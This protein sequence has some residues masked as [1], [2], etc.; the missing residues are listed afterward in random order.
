MPLTYPDIDPVAFTI[1]GW[2]VHWYGM[3]YILA[4][5]AAAFLGRWLLHRAAFAGRMQK[6]VVD[7]L[8][9]AALIGVLVG[10]RLGYVLFYHPMHFAAEPWRIIEVWSGGMSFHGGLLG[11][12]VGVVIYARRCGIPFWRVADFAAVITPPGLA[13][14]R[15][16]N[17]ING[18]LPGRIA[19]DWV[20]WRLIYEHIDSLPRHPSAI[21]QA[22]L[23]GGVLLGLMLWLARRRRAD[24]VIAGSFLVGYGLCRMVS[25]LFREPDLHLGLLFGGLSMGQWLSLPM[26]MAGAYIIYRGLSHSTLKRD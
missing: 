15:L 4:F 1:F 5:M 21:Y 12:V 25:E 17:F 7:D 13:L 3:M 14:G 18:E 23:E 8:L 6:F 19:A 11:V 2:P 22:L 20:P 24:G 26:L 9:L 10:G 16:G